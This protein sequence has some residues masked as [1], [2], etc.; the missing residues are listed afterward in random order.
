MKLF[1]EEE[2]AG[3]HE[4]EEIREVSKHDIVE[5]I[6]DYTLNPEAIKQIAFKIKYLPTPDLKKL[7]EQQSG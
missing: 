5:L 7:F 1:G 4:E 2:E 6:E 3:G